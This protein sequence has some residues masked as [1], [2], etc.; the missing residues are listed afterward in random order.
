MISFWLV[1]KEYFRSKTGYK[2]VILS[3]KPQSPWLQPVEVKPLDGSMVQKREI[4][5]ES[6]RK[7]EE[8]ND[9]CRNW[10]NYESK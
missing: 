10:N 4:P 2:A 9:E 7:G 6:E 8:I 3:K 5:K 1:G